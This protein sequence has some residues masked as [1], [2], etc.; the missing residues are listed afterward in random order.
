MGRSRHSS[1]SDDNRRKAR[2]VSKSPSPVGRRK[3][4]SRS[5]E[6]RSRSRSPKRFQSGGFKSSGGREREEE[7]SRC[8]GVFGLSGDT[9]EAELEKVFGKH[10]DIERVTVLKDHATGE[11]RKF[12]FVT[13]VSLD[14]A[15]KARDEIHGMSIDGRN[16]RVDYSI[17]KG[18][19]NF[20]DRSPPRQSFRRRS[21]SP[22]S[23]GRRDDSREDRYERRGGDRDDRRRHDDD[24]RSSRRSPSPRGYR[25]SPDY[26]R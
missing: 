2:R 12:G 23:R 25:R 1:D 7:P 3:S 17:M 24:R 5:A 14:S 16:V 19:D 15:I 10:G 26:G 4:R 6:K 8:V 22:V 21:P 13:F 18:R 20:R 11:S 9:R